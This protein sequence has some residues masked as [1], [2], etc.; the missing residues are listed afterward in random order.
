MRP[1]KPF[2]VSPPRQ[3]RKNRSEVAFFSLSPKQ[4]INIKSGN[5]RISSILNR[6]IEKPEAGQYDAI[7]IAVAHQAFIDLGAEHIHQLGKPVHVVF[8]VKWCLPQHQSDE[9][10]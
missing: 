9:R 4:I 1:I 10:L 8:D 2:N 7:V 3:F 5:D 6:L